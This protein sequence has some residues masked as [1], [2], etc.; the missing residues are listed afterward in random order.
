[1]SELQEEI[2]QFLD[3]NVSFDTFEYSEQK[4]LDHQK[5]IGSVKSLQIHEGVY[6]KNIK[7]NN[8]F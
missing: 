6:F 3:K 4:K 8:I 2:L 1:M 7:K 5:V